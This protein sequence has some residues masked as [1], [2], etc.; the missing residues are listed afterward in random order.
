MTDDDRDQVLARRARFVAA[1]LT[2]VGLA[3]SCAKTQSHPD[4]CLSPPQPDP[5]SEV[6]E[7]VDPPVVEGENES[8][9]GDA[10]PLPCLSPWTSGPPDSD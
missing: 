3:A 1:A 8:D 2:S 10:E 7:D 6:I 5:T 4:V 9:A